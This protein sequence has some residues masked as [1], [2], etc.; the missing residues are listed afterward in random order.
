[1]ARRIP[2]PLVG[3]VRVG[4]SVL[5]SQ[6]VALT[7]HFHLLPAASRVFPTCVLRERISGTPE[8]RGEE[9]RLALPENT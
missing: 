7:P 2:L 3:R 9:N 6:N 5:K 4:V 8:I 1:M